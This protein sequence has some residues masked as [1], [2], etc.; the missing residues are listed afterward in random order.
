MSA[1]NLQGAPALG[2]LP[3]LPVRRNVTVTEL[4]QYYSAGLAEKIVEPLSATYGVG[5]GGV[6]WAT[7]RAANTEGLGLAYYQQGSTYQLQAFTY[8]NDTF[9][10]RGSAVTPAHTS[11]MFGANTLRLPDGTFLCAHRSTANRFCR[12]AVDP[13]TYAVTQTDYF[14]VVPTSGVCVSGEAFTCSPTGG[15]FGYSYNLGPNEPNW[16]VDGAEIVLFGTVDIAGAAWVAAFVF[17]ASGQLVRVH[18][19]FTYTLQASSAGT[20]LHVRRVNAYYHLCV[21][22]RGPSTAYN[23]I[24]RYVCCSA[25]FVSDLS[26]V[27]GEVSWNDSSSYYNKLVMAADSKSVL[28]FIVSTNG[29]PL[30]MYTS[31]ARLYKLD[32]KGKP[33]ASTNNQLPPFALNRSGSAESTGLMNDLVYYTTY[34]SSEDAFIRAPNYATS[35]GRCGGNA[36]T[37]GYFAVSLRHDQTATNQA[38]IYKGGYRFKTLSDANDDLLLRFCPQVAVNQVDDSASYSNYA[39]PL[40]LFELSSGYWL[41]LSQLASSNYRLQLYKEQA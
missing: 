34:S 12:V 15:D 23:M 36:S 6:L 35:T 19:L 9:Q 33:I 22:N 5:A 18:K 24:G 38:H 17:N 29:T 14:M 27:F 25:D 7:G 11:A 3:G 37:G 4:N 21:L 1:Y 2:K 16:F 32:E 40:E 26:I 30:T 10:M 13:N 39:E 8:G 28:F 20:Y 31:F 41:G